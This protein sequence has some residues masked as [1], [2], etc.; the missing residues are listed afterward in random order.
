MKRLVIDN[1]ESLHI[2]DSDLCAAI[3]GLIKNEEYAAEFDWVTI[4]DKSGNLID[5][6]RK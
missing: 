2:T 4:L 5:V 1:Y 3:R 6:I